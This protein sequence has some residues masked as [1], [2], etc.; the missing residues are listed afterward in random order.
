VDK[1]PAIRPDLAGL[2]DAGFLLNPIEQGFNGL[3]DA[4]DGSGQSLIG[5]IK[6][7]LMLLFFAGS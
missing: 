3:A 5:S 1:Q 6:R 2:L 7:R 4:A